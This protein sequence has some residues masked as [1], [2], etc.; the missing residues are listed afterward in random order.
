MRR[1]N[2]Q[3][4]V[5]AAGG[6]GVASMFSTR[7]LLA[8]L[9]AAALACAAVPALAVDKDW[10]NASDSNWNTGSNWAPFGVPGTNDDV[11]IGRFPF[12]TGARVTMDISD[13]V[14][15]LNII[16]GELDTATFELIVDSASINGANAEL[17]IK[18]NNNGVNDSLDADFVDVTNGGLIRM[19][20]GRLEIDG[21]TGDGALDVSSGSTLLGYGNIDLEDIVASNAS[22]FTLSSS[23]LSVGNTTD[24]FIIPLFDTARTLSINATDVDTTADLDQG[25]VA[26]VINLLAAGT[27]DLN[28]PIVPA[29]DGVYNGTMNLSRRSVLDV[30]DDWTFAGVMNVNTTAGLG[31]TQTAAPATLRGGDGIG[32][33]IT[34]SG[35][36]INLDNAD[37]HLTID[38]NGQFTATG[39][40]INLTLGT[41]QF[42][43]TTNIGAGVDFS[44]GPNNTELIVNATVNIDDADFDWDGG[45][46][47]TTLTTINPGGNLDL[48]ITGFDGNDGYG[49]GINMTGGELDVNV[50]DN[51]WSFDGGDTFDIN[52]AGTTATLNGDTMRVFGTVNVNSGTFDANAQTLWAAGARI[53]VDNGATARLDGIHTFFNNTNIVVNG[54]LD[55]NGTTTWLGPAQV[56]GTGTIVNDGSA[57]V[58]GD[59]VIEVATFD[60]DQGST[61]ILSSGSLTLDVTNVDIGNDTFNGQ[62]ITVNDAGTLEVTVN[63]GSWNMDG[64]LNL[65]DTGVVGTPTVLTGSEMRVGGTVNVIGARGAINT[66]T[67]LEEGGVVEID[68][69]NGIFDMNATLTLDGGDITGNGLAGTDFLPATM[70]VTGE[71]AINVVTYNMDGGTLTLAPGGNLDVNVTSIETS[72]PETFDT[73]MNFTG[74]IINVN[75]AANQWTMDG[76]INSNGGGS[77][78]GDE[79]RI[80]DGLETLNADVN[81]NSGTLN[82]GAPVIFL[83]DADVNVAA[84]A[85]LNVTNANT[86]FITGGTAEF[87]GQGTLRIVGADFAQDQVINMT[88]G[89]VALDGSLSGNGAPFVL[90]SAGDND[91]N[92]DITINAAAIEDYGFQ[93][94]LPA[95]TSELNIS[96]NASLTVNLDNPASEWTVTSIGVINYTGDFSVNNFLEGSDINLNG[97]LNVTGDGRTNA[98][99]DI[100]STGDINMTGGGPDEGLRLSGG[101]IGDPNTIAGGTITGNATGILRSDSGIALRGFGTINADIAFGGTGELIAAD[102]GTLDVNGDITDMGT[103]RANGGTLDIANNLLSS[104]TSNGISLDNGTLTGTGFIT[105]DVRN[106]RGNGSVFS[107]IVNNVSIRAQGGT[108][109]IDDPSTNLDGNSPDGSGL[110]IAETGTLE[111][112]TWFNENFNGTATVESGRTIFANSQDV[113]FVGGSVL[114]LNGGRYRTNDSHAFTGTLNATGN[115]EIQT[116]G[117]ATFAFNSGATVNADGNLLI[118][119]TVFFNASASVGGAGAI[120]VGN[121]STVFIADGQ[122]INTLLNSLNGGDV[123]IGTTGGAIANIAVQDYDVNGTHNVDLN[124]TALN[125]FDR[126]AVAGTLD[127]NAVTDV[128]DLD[129]AFAAGLGDLFTVFTAASIVGQFDTVDV[130]GLGA[131]LDVSVNYNPLSVV[132]EI[133]NAIS[134]ITGDYNS[135]GQVEQGDLD[136]VLQN[137]GTGNFPG[138]EAALVGG[139]PFDGTVDQNELDGVL[140]NW[141][142]T[143]APDFS[144][145][146]AAVPE[147]AGFALL[148]GAGLGV[149]RRRRSA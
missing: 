61:N 31:A 59:A 38:T 81:V 5:R 107:P 136:I 139:G 57:Q 149:M 28:V 58:Q 128:L 92:A 83:G 80:G 106:L 99:L 114:N 14:Q 102:G 101:T 133:V 93:T 135:S 75:N 111:L 53:E 21:N 67:V 116:D 94:F 35:G 65:T 69:I 55:L 98:R 137:W 22:R 90:T 110:I 145:N 3:R 131:G 68:S 12:P 141:G 77:L 134:V 117:G 103:L 138:D 97:T 140:Q 148:A 124:G 64:T 120:N 79:V 23:T 108:L 86:L 27:L 33:S 30:E 48:D 70:I 109:I 85:T 46:G 34:M 32:A 49:G 25:G 52:A 39:G 147:P 7:R 11:F 119:G 87:T 76:A 127:L 9:P 78:F 51:E 104:V 125:Q 36:S 44:M 143:S 8:V 89:T 72:G 121:G 1:M 84:G 96:N 146:L 41:I 10:N 54:T 113:R 42:D 82:L 19:L 18:P 71:S 132:V 15:T 43:S 17:L 40:T 29:S 4:A 26:A 60:W 47:P 126:T 6:I 37:D 142:N 118:D 66:A 16:N 74:G 63:D 115:A 144:A 122:S 45:G 50:A 130:S 95:A 20:G 62:T 105:L 73:T 91:I 123:E 24:G 100:G 129:F 88:G 13:T 56:V 112:R 2:K